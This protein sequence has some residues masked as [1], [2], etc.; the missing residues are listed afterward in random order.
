MLNKAIQRTV[1]VAILVASSDVISKEISYNYIQGTYISTSVDSDAAGGDI[2]GNGFGLSG[3][4]S[5][6]PEL[7]I[8]AS[9]GGRSFDTFQGVDVDSTSLTLGVTFYSSGE[10]GTS[11]FANISA[12]RGEVESTNGFTTIDDNDTGFIMSFGLRHMATDA[13]ELEL[14]YFHTDIF[15]DTDN[16]VGLGAR[17]Y[18]TEKFSL[19]I[20]YETSNDIDTLLL[21]ARFNI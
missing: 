15:D 1:L 5:V 11:A 8:T 19:G 12:L 16:T 9:Y 21:N 14:N 4:F 18:A 2:D 10:S 13:L 17:F 7:A 3:S 6:A 20:G